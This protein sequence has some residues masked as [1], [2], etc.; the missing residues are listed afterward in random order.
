MDAFELRVLVQPTPIIYDSCIRSKLPCL[1]VDIECILS[2]P[3][4]DK[5]FAPLMLVEYSVLGALLSKDTQPKSICRIV[6]GTEEERHEKRD[7]KQEKHAKKD[8][9]T[10]EQLRL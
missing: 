7:R 6:K 5:E 2:T 3:A 1:Q 9:I 8:S 10:D 4:Q